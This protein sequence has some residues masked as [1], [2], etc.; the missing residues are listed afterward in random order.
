ME[1]PDPN[2]AYLI[3]VLQDRDWTTAREI[4]E[5]VKRQTE[6]VWHDRKV[7]ELA[8]QS[9]GAV[10]GGQRGYKLIG[11]M[12]V[13]EYNHWRNWMTSQAAEMTSRVLQ[14]DKVFYRRKAV[15]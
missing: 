11:L 8:S 2:V 9:K 12:T 3:A 6:V 10:A 5:I 4:I 7:R 15:A 13:E 1:K 14:A